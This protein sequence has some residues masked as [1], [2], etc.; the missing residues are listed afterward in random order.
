MPSACVPRAAA[1]RFCL[2]HGSRCRIE[3]FLDQGGACG[4]AGPAS[5]PGSALREAPPAHAGPHH[6]ARG[7]HG[8]SY[9]MQTGAGRCHRP[10]LPIVQFAATASMALPAGRVACDRLRRPL[11]RR[12]LPRS[13]APA[14]AMDRTRSYCAMAQARH[15]GRAHCRVFFVRSP[16]DLHPISTYLPVAQQRGA[17]GR[18]RTPPQSHR[19][20]VQDR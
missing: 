3:P 7:D 2:H 9:G 10:R 15:P 19:P 1:P 18:L 6:L 20:G 8:S 12:P 16:H 11:T 14:R 5:A 17:Y 4:T 13:L